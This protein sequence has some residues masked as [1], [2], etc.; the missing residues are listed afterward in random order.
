MAKSLWILRPVDT[1]S[2]PWSSQYDMAFGFVIRAESEERARALLT[3]MET[4][5]EVVGQRD[6]WTNPAFSTCVEL[7]QDGEDG[8]IMRDFWSG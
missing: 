4:G 5:D 3:H 1:N 6:A 8:I 2:A 7:T